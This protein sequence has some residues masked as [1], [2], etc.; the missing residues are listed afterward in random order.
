MS[1]DKKRH[2]ISHEHPHLSV[3]QQCDA[4]KIHRSGIYF[5]P[6]GEK[7]L[8]LRL[9][10]LIDAKFMDCPFYGVPRM[11]T[12]LREDMGYI[13]NEKRIARL[14][15]LM[16]LQTIFPKKNLSK[17][18]QQHKI[19]PY[20]LRNMK[21]TRA[22]QVWETDITYIPLERGFMYCLAFIDVYSR[23]IINWSI[24]NTM[25]VEWCVQVY[26]DAIK[27]FGCPEI[28]NTDQGSQFTSPLFT[29][30]SLDNDVQLSMD[31]KGRA[32]DNI[33]IER[34]WRSLKYEHIYLNPAN[35]GVE[36]YEGVRKYI[37]FYNSE[38]RH[39]SINNKTP[40]EFYKQMK[41]VS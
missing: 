1:L 16:G 30:I 25:N 18:N 4:L 12:W 6:K 7:Q 5:K 27:E 35:G 37:Q 11:T 39:T 32:L 24:S 19:Y 41:N 2:L 15:Q 9:M 22:N 29:K 34:F 26:E 20:L 13:V 28:L 40:N 38:R 33:Y 23:K 31:G 36:L 17:R 14:Y 21:I 3:V 10:R 8:N